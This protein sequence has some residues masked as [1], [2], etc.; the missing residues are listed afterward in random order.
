MN[1]KTATINKTNNL[2]AHLQATVNNYE[3]KCKSFGI[4]PNWASEAMKK[5]EANGD[6][7]ALIHGLV[8]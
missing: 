3:A 4:N 1:A 7:F 5:A 2:P 6:D 8:K